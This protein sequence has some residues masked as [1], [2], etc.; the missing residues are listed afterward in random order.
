M[1]YGLFWKYDDKRVLMEDYLE[2]KY[3]DEFL[4]D[5]IEFGWSNGGSYFTYAEATSTKAHFYIE[6]SNDGTFEDYYVLEY[7]SYEGLEMIEPIVSTIFDQYFSVS[8]DLSFQKKIAHFKELKGNLDFIK[9]KLDIVFLHQLCDENQ[10]KE[11][12]KAL[13]LIEAL[14]N[15]RFVIDQLDIAYICATISINDEDLSQIH[16]PEDLKDYIGIRE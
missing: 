7:W 6:V 2:E 13:Q 12:E 10:S 14:R 16:H 5:D 4:L 8:Y 15:N 3:K 9:W 1:N 11:L